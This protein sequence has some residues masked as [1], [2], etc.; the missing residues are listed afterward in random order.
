MTETPDLAASG[1]TTND[2]EEEICFYCRWWKPRQGGVGWCDF[3]YPV[4][5]RGLKN[6]YETCEHWEASDV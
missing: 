2:E 5:H 6:A 4:E 3:N 1:Q